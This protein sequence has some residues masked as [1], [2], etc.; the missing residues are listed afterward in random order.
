MTLEFEA[1]KFIGGAFLSIFTAIISID[2][3]DRLTPAINEVDELKKGNKAVAVFLGAVVL[4]ICLMV[5][6]SLYKFA[7]LGESPLLGADLLGWVWVY[8]MSLLGAIFV[9]YASFAAIDAYTQKINE[10]EELKNGNMAVAIMLAAV[11]VSI[12]L[13]ATVAVWETVI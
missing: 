3:F 10:I 11:L 1:G 12:S 8:I 4:G 13:L 9:M 5:V 6:P 2:I 7:K